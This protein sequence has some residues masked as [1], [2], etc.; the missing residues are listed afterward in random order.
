[1]AGEED[2]SSGGKAMQPGVS[3][4]VPRGVP[5]VTPWHAPGMDPSTVSQGSA[6]HG[7]CPVPMPP[8]TRDGAG[9]ICGTAPP[10]WDAL[11][12][13][14]S[15]LA[16]CCRPSGCHPWDEMGPIT[17]FSW[18]SPLPPSH[19]GGWHP[20]HPW[21]NVSWGQLLPSPLPDGLSSWGRAVGEDSETLPRCG[22]GH[23]RGHQGDTACARGWPCLA[24][25]A[26]HH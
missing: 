25:R 6:Q 15:P 24:G 13:W 19:P 1:M 16:S 2:S 3:P 21:P 4:D 23:P 10:G 8:R 7:P 20:A 11:T 18:S 9:S 5:V 26:G 14:A 17:T 22:P 12:T